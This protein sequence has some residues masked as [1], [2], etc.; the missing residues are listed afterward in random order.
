MNKRITVLVAHEK[1]QAWGNVRARLEQFLLEGLIRPFV[2][3]SISS[4]DDL[5]IDPVIDVVELGEDAEVKTYTST[6]FGFLASLGEISEVSV[7]GLRCDS[8]GVEDN[9]SKSTQLDKALQSIRRL[10]IQF[11]GDLRQRQVR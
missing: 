7:V 4:D 6:F 3:V 5:G 9:I 2:V 1:D 8:S 11:A 10:L